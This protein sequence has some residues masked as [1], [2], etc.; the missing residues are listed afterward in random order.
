MKNKKITGYALILQKGDCYCKTKD[1]G[2]VLGV[3]HYRVICSS[4]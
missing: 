2:I 3:K 4:F 1:K